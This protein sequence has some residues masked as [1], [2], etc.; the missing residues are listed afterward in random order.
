L[1]GNLAALPE[2]G[3]RD[4]HE[5]ARRPFGMPGPASPHGTVAPRMT[6]RPSPA[7][8]ERTV[9]ELAIIDELSFRP[10]AVYADLKEVLR[11]DNYVFRVLSGRSAA[12]W[13]RALF[14]NLTYWDVGAGDVLDDHRV[15]ADVVA[16]AAWHHLAAI[17]LPAKSQS[18]EALFLGE[19]IA[20]AFDIYLVGRLLGRA[21]RS[22]F[23]E[24]QVPAMAESAKAA[25]LGARAFEALLRGVAADPEGSFGQLRQLLYDATCALVACRGATEAIKA[26][27]RF[28]AHRF[29]PLLHHYELSNWIL[30]A[31]AHARG[32]IKDVHARAIARALARHPSPLA[33]LT[34]QWV[35]PR[36][37]A[38]VE[39]ASGP[40][41]GQAA[42]REYPRRRDR[43]GIGRKTPLS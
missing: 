8:A 39:R 34:S 43:E 27:A 32:G 10:I 1:D 5:R 6:L 22:S 42:P 23:L 25:G 21:R 7:L 11:R 38:S 29:G 19:S 14:L 36:L 31:R 24:T 13:D 16:H 37:A 17:A 18:V 41:A 3:E 35:V 26:L 4:R 12:R 15:A 2:G 20:S 28:E 33:W 9:D 30:Y 40:G